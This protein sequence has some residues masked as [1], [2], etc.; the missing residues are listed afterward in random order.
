PSTAGIYEDLGIF[1]T[2]PDVCSDLSQLFNKLTGYV[3]E[4]TYK[5]LLVAPNRMRDEIV[6]RIRAQA[7]LG[8]SG[9]IIMKCNNFVDTQLINE[10]YAASQQ[11]VTVQL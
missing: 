5:A 11:G 10:L 7:S 4:D 9:H 2:R 8:T 6:E 1:T 3:A